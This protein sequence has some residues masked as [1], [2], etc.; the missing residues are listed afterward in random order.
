MT[1]CLFNSSLRTL[2]LANMGP[3]ILVKSTGEVREGGDA[4]RKALSEEIY[5]PFKE[6]YHHP[7]YAICAQTS[8]KT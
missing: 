7:N 8:D 1:V 4:S 2:Q 5:A 6:Y 3:D